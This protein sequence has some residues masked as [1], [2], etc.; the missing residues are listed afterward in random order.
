[1]LYFQSIKQL[2]DK[3]Y[4]NK[5]R[6]CNYLSYSQELVIKYIDNYIKSALLTKLFD[7]SDKVKTIQFKIHSDIQRHVIAKLY[8]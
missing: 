2:A 8:M 3:K 7:E 5:S 4:N 1:M 6:H